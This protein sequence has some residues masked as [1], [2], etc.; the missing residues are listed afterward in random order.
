MPWSVFG[1]DRLIPMVNYL[2]KMTHEN[3][4]GYF[5]RY[6]VERMLITELLGCGANERWQ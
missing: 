3:E 2:Y 1:N 4:D 5:V 6:P